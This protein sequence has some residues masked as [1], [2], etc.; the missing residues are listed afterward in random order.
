[1]PDF[2]EAKV[3]DRVYSMKYGWG[4]IEKFS[5][6]IN[7]IFVV[8]DDGNAHGYFFSGYFVY[9]PNREFRDLYW[10]VP[11]IIDPPRPKEKK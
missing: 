11:Q 7:R 9:S 4:T 10:D 2:S 8:F 5:P 6:S 1:M 3:D